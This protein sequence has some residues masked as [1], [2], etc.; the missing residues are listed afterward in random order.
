[1]NSA[2]LGTVAGRP[3]G[4]MVSPL[5]SLAASSRLSLSRNLTAAQTA[6]DAWKQADKDQGAAQDA[7]AHAVQ[8]LR[9]MVHLINTDRRTLQTAAEILYPCK[10]ASNGPA[11]RAFG[12]PVNRPMKM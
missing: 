2:G 5:V 10:N 12:L 8:A 11:R 3:G 9:D 6:L 7:Y 1:M 4:V